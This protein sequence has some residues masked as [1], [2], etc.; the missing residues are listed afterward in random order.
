VTDLLLW[1]FGSTLLV[2]LM[3]L[4]GVT[5]FVVR[6]KLLERVL[7]ALVGF[8]AG[9]LMGGAFL[10][11]LPE[12]L[13]HSESLSIFS[14]VI[15]G[16][17]VFFL[18]EKFLYWR[19][20]HKGECDVHTFTY[21]NLIGDGIHNFTDGIAIAASFMAGLPLG[22]ATTLAVMAHEV[23]QEFGDFGVLVYGGFSRSRALF[24]NFIDQ[25]TAI[26]GGI[27]GYVLFPYVAGLP[28]LILPFAAGGF[29]Y[30]AGSDLI[31]ELHREPDL[32]KSVLS[33]TFFLVGL[34]FMR[35]VGL[36]FEH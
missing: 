30:I 16:F 32:K 7:L 36:V 20:C 18:M 5:T 14:Y 9:A 21:M 25:T 35:S 2:S 3:S 22:I 13:E 34:L 24:F 10:H 27:T 8:S 6:G 17:A 26:L 12:A 19:H 23:P 1:I 4:V 11:M 31:P 33:F 15:F 28:L 29:I